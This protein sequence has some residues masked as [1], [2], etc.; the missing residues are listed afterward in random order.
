[1]QIVNFIMRNSKSSKDE[2][3]IHVAE[4]TGKIHPNGVWW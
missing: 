1:M 4:T 2:E 3:D